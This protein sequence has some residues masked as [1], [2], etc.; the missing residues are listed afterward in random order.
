MR[1]VQL[2]GRVSLLEVIGKSD[3]Q[4]EQ[5]QRRI[6][7]ARRR[8]YGAAGNEQAIDAVNHGVGIDDARSRIGSHAGG[9]G[10]VS[11]IHEDGQGVLP[12]RNP[13]RQHWLW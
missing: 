13:I 6:G 9:A 3:R 2:L 1:S 10:R 8:K 5:H 4:G 7:V 12:C 11:H